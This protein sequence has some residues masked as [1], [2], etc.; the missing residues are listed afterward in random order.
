M[1]PRKPSRPKNKTSMKMLGRQIAAA[2]R[3]SGL[4]QVELAAIVNIDDET[5]ASIEQGRRPLK[6]DIGRKIDE[7]LGTKGVFEEGAENLPEIDQYPL[8]AE[9]YIEHERTAKKLDWFDNAVIP[10][11]LQTEEYAEAVLRERVPAYSEEEIQTK[12]AGRIERM[13]ILRRE[14]G[15]TMSFVIW[16]PVLHMMVGGP[17]VQQRQLRH[18]RELADLPNVTI[19]I[20]PLD[21]LHH[22]GLNGP[23]TL[24]ETEDHQH[25]AYTES[26]RGSH[27]VSDPEEM[28]ILE[29]K[30]AMLRTQA[31]DVEKSKRKLDCLLGEQ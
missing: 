18:L 2:R 21:S 26:Q 20:L 28:S 8:F 27:W 31:L 22:A 13:A 24:L 14:N 5:M 17:E 1:S 7:A 25:L 16:E 6:P 15:P 4:T 12:L 10:G 9:E 23:F 3:A 19:Q 30:Y 29:S 11:L